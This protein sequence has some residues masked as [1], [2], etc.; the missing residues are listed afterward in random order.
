MNTQINIGEKPITK[1]IKLLNLK[2]SKKISSPITPQNNLKNL[3]PK[4]FFE[5]SNQENKFQKCDFSFKKMNSDE[6]KENIKIKNLLK[7]NINKDNIL[8][9]ISCKIDSSTNSH[10]TNNTESGNFNSKEINKEKI[11]EIEEDNFKE[12]PHFF[13]K[14]DICEIKNN[15]NIISDNIVLKNNLV[16][17]EKVNKEIKNLFDNLP[18]NLKKDPDVNEKVGMLLKNIYE[19]KQIINYK[20]DGINYPNTQRNNKKINQNNNRPLSSRNLISNINCIKMGPKGN[21]RYVKI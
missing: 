7:T 13:P 10:S 11:D 3:F 6:P 17:G 9:K 19:M 20:K 4:D 2:P 5:N 18:E 8:Y 21:S 1:T 16:D 14:I 12:T 15:S